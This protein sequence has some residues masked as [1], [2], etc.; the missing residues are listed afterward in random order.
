VKKLLLIL[1]AAGAAAVAVKEWPALR[2][3]LKIMGM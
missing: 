3:E 1:L 2:R